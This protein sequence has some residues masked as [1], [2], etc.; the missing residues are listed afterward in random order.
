MLIPVAWFIRYEF[1]EMNT[2]SKPDHLNAWVA[3]VSTESGMIIDFNFSHSWK[4][5]MLMFF[6]FDSSSNVTEVSFLHSLNMLL[7]IDVT[8]FGISIDSKFV[9]P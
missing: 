1:S 8:D 7:P 3:I 9:Q 2:V 4:A 5:Y 6:S